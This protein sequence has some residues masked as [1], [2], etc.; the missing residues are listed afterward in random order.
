MMIYALVPAAY[1]IGSIPTGIMVTRLFTGKDIR[2]LGSGNVGA[3]NVG[4]I[5]GKWAGGLVLF[6]DMAKGAL[7]VSLALLLAPENDLFRETLVALA[8]LSAVLGHLYPVYFRGHSGGK[9]VAPAA[10]CFALL[11]PLALFGVLFVYLLAAYRWRIA[12]VGSLS[13]ASALPF[14]VFLETGSPVY[15][16]LG[17]AVAGLIFIRHAENIRRIRKGVEPVWKA[18]DTRLKEGSTRKKQ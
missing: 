17:I 4:R 11:T 15:F 5:A 12:S 18:G 7:P 10:G 16:L 14:L 1:L 6:G 2:T 8:A 13:G 9:G 3:A